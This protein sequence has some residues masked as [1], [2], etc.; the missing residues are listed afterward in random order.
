VTP[1]LTYYQGTYTTLA[2]MNTAL[3]GGLTGSSTAP[4]VAG[5]YTVVASFAGSTDYSSGQALATFTI[6]QATP[7]VQ[8]S[9]PGGLYNQ[10][11]FAATATVAGVDNTAAASLENVTPTLAYYQGSTVGGT[12]LSGAPF[13]PGT[14]TVQA[15]FAGSTDYVS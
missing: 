9:D 5:S 13:L 1:T 6:G 15:S 7:T 4:S 11:A 8:V 3:A 10:A 12:A 14:Y 2:A